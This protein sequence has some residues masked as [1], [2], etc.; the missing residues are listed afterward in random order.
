MN[1]IKKVK[2]ESFNRVPNQFVI[3]TNEGAYFQSYNSIIVF[4]P[5]D[6][7]KTQLDKIYWK[8]SVTTSKHR[9]AFLGETTKETEAKIKSGEYVLTNLN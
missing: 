4:V 2:V 6:K 8:Y 1:T 7:D 3:H 9:N 5:A